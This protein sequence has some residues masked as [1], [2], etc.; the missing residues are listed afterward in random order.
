MVKAEKAT[1]KKR[2]RIKKEKKESTDTS[3]KQIV[4]CDFCDQIFNS[5]KLRKDHCLGEL[6]IIIFIISLPFM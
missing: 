5:L 6:L 2:K 1:P 4:K 3:P